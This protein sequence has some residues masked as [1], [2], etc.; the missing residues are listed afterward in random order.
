M[1]IALEIPGTS[2]EKEAMELQVATKDTK[3]SRFGS[4]ICLFQ[5]DNYA[6]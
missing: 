6:L 1:E 2:K 5:A 3:D 4:D